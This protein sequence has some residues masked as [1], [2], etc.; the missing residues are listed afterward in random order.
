MQRDQLCLQLLLF[1]VRDVVFRWRTSGRYRLILAIPLIIYFFWFM[2]VVTRG[3][4]KSEQDKFDNSFN[5]E[6]TKKVPIAFENQQICALDTVDLLII[7]ISS[8]LNFHQRQAIRETWASMPDLFTIHAQR[9]F[10]IGYQTGHNFEHELMQEA[11]QERDLLYLTIDDRLATLKEIY[12]YLWLKNHCGYVIYTFKTNDEL[13]VNTFLLH[14]IVGELKKNNRENSNRNLYGA[15]LDSM[16]QAKDGRS[17]KR[18]LFGRIVEAEEPERNDLNS[19]FYLSRDEYSKDLYP[20]YCSGTSSLR[21][22]IID[23]SKKNFL[24]VQ[25]GFGYLMDSTTR[26]LLALEAFKVRNQL[27]FADI[28]ITGIIPERLNFTCNQLPL[29]ILQGTVKKCSK[30]ILQIPRNVNES[31]STPPVLVCSLSNHLTESSFNDYH[32]LWDTLKENYSNRI[33]TMT[34]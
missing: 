8:T 10:I 24:L 27:R 9:L 22:F 6:T 15:Q 14:E 32:N 26:N 23:A 20:S 7:I 3:R 16:F 11:I 1:H 28:F 21:I 25:S 17:L 2:A 33:V 18:F 4:F 12:A 34:S 31:A 5:N 19:Q 13:F 29:T 30:L